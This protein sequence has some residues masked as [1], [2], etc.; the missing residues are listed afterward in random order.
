M[1]PHRIALGLA[2]S[3]GTMAHIAYAEPQHGIAMYGEPA[4][5]P[6]FTE[7]PYV[8]P[9]APKGGR[10]VFGESG[11]FDAFNPYILKGRSPWGL[12]AHVFE[13]LLGRSWDESF[14]LYGLLAESVETGP[15]REWVEFHLRPEAAFSDGSPVTVDDVIWSFEILAEKGLPSFGNS[16]KKVETVERVGE[17]GV[18]FTF[19][20]VDFELPLILGLRPILK[21]S[22]WEGR[23]FAESTL[24]V[25]TATGPYTVGDFEAGRYIS[26][27]R[28]PDYWGKDLPFNKGRNNLDEIRYEFYGDAGVVW[29]SFT[30]GETSV[31]REGDPVK[32]ENEY[33]FPLVTSGEVTKSV[34]PHQRPAGMEGFVFNT[35]RP[36]FEDWRVR[37]ALLHAFNFEFINQALNNGVYPRRTSYFANSPLGMA[38]GEPA[39]GK[40]AELLAPFADELLPGAIDG[41]A[42]PVS[43]GSER[44]RSNLRA[45]RQQLEA[46]GWTIQDGE[47]KDADGNPFT[48]EIMLKSNRDE[49]LANMW[50]DAL[51]QL[52]IT[53]GIELVDSAQHKARATEYDYDMM[54]NRW[55]LSLSPGN[56][57]RFYWGSNG[58]TEPG[59]RNYM[60]VNSPAA[61]A[62]IDAMLSAES[63]EDFVAATKALDRVLT[64]GRYVVP[65]WFSDVSRLA[66]AS[67]LKY[68]ETLPI[69][70]DWIGFLPD[71]WWNEE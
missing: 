50:F 43:D 70:G 44:N 67:R 6:D 55:G 57:Q 1:K 58:V 4:L 23:D 9:D 53:P 13:S 29:Q 47:L 30:A 18:R 54:V 59:T 32:W 10:I 39:E 63:Q 51:K 62:M 35:R 41:Y 56:E 8:N 33:D 46:A 34:I 68:P 65:F 37:D 27:V 45:A 36:I 24:D 61:D 12:R 11:G 16:W 42:L 17:R 20:T 48:F 26:F 21:Q 3:L 40:V 69:Y 66:H 14:T 19:N 28:N 22:D 38:V 60:G 71:V 5:G 49:G 64:S 7:L 15:N 52:G 25:P 31:F 2:L